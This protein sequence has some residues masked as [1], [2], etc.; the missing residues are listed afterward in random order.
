MIVHLVMGDISND[1]REQACPG[2]INQVQRAAGPTISARSLVR[3]VHVEQTNESF[4]GMDGAFLGDQVILFP[5][6]EQ[7]RLT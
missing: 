4:S 2:V 7:R 1:Q 5:S 3:G 6:G